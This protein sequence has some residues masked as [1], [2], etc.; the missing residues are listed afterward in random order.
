[1]E[2]LKKVF[3]Y[4]II[5]ACLL[6]VSEIIVGVASNNPPEYL[7]TNDGRFISAISIVV[8]IVFVWRKVSQRYL[9]K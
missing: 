4:I 3:W 6:D 7:K 2:M 8:L 1:M 5:F 9:K